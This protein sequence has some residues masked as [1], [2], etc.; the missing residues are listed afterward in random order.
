[1]I[2]KFNIYGLIP[3]FL[4]PG[5]VFSIDPYE[6][7]ESLLPR[8]HLP[9]VLNS[10]D[11]VDFNPTDLQP[12]VS[13]SA[14]FNKDG[15]EDIVISGL[16]GL[17]SNPKPY[18]LLVATRH[19]NPIRL[20]TLYYREFTQPV[21]IHLPGTTGKGDP[22]DQSFSISL[23][24][25]CHLGSD[26]YWNKKEKTFSILPWKTKTRHVASKVLP[27]EDIPE[28]IV[29]KALKIVGKLKDVQEYIEHLKK[30][31]RSFGVR[32]EPLK[33]SKKK[34]RYGVRIYE[35]KEGGETLYD[36]FVVDVKKMRVKKRN[37]KF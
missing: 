24:R 11:I 16:Y 21:F 4:C 30:E 25:D 17:T 23:C 28:E 1:M 32:V 12:L 8:E 31:G 27:D 3:L 18:F 6:A 13:P 15:L 26:F 34:N 2:R 37:L 22:G 20:E 10:D 33:N 5:L 36:F 35:K 14:D 7:L 19:T 9:R 29:D